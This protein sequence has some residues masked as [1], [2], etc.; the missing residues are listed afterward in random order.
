MMNGSNTSDA[1]FWAG[2][3]Y[4]ATGDSAP[5]FKVT[6]SGEVYIKKLQVYHNNKWETIDL[7]KNFTDAVSYMGGTWNGTTKKLSATIGLY[8]TL[9]KVLEIDG[10]DIW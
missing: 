3:L 9:T 7:T 4:S 1:A 5:G 6:K 10:S 2:G 8:S